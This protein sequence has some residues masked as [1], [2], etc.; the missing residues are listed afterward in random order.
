[1]RA[2][3][4]AGDRLTYVQADVT[5][6][7]SWN[8]AVAGR[9]IRA[10]VHAA[11]ITPN[12]QG[13]PEKAK[14]VPE[15]DIPARIL[16]VNI[17]GTVQMLEFAR[18]CP[19]L[20]RFI[21]VSSGSVYGDHG[22]DIAGA[23]LPEDGWVEPHELYAV[24]KYSSELIT[25]RYAE[26]FGLSAVSVRLSGVFGP[27]DRATPARTYECAPNR[28]AHLA[29]AGRTIRVDRLDA[30][31]DWISAPDIARALVHLLLAESPRHSVYNI[32]QGRTDTVADLLRHTRAVLPQTRWQESAADSA[33]VLQGGP[34]TGGRWS[35]YDIARLRDEFGWQPTPLAAA[36]AEY[37]GWIRQIEMPARALR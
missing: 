21:Y 5:R 27:F 4:D 12:T 14:V 32:A 7:E 15:R 24:S 35:A 2:F 29:L 22:P 17:M 28:V 16:D 3:A 1:R 10:I 30:I 20:K 6:P 18:Q 33:D 25:R 11:T 8:H 36:M 13:P 26:L 34:Y 37:I 31:G 23:P 19:D 9:T